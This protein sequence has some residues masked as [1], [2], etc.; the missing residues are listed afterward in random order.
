MYALGPYLGVGGGK[1]PTPWSVPGAEAAGLN[2]GKPTKGAVM[3]TDKRFRSGFLPGTRPQPLQWAL[4]CQ[5]GGF[6]PG[7]TPRRQSLLPS[8]P[9]APHPGHGPRRR[10]PCH[11][12]HTPRA[13]T[14]HIRAS[15]LATGTRQRARP[16]RQP[17]LPQHS[18]RGPIAPLC[19]PPCG[20][21]AL[22]IG[23]T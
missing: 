9:S 8:R 17:G 2:M 3:A 14:H 22:P 1:D 5:P 18:A 6:S 10:D 11:P 16:S 21:Q 7:H 13:T 20:P 15:P 4:S 23:V 19:S 12:R